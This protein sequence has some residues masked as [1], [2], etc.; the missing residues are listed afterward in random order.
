MI[1]YVQVYGSP[2]KADHF[3]VLYRLKIKTKEI[4]GT[5]A[6]KYLIYENLVFVTELI[7]QEKEGCGIL[8]YSSLECIDINTFEKKSF[9]KID[10][11]YV[12]PL[13]IEGTKII[14]TK[15]KKGSSA[16]HEFEQEIMGNG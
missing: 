3:Y 2:S 13:K 1:D 5:F 11:G 14:Y 4:K 15:Q 10:D 8:K 6:D 12:Y 7:L 9:S 16:V